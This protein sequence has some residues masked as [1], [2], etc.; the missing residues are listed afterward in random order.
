MTKD[1]ELVL[2]EEYKFEYWAKWLKISLLGNFG[3][4]R[5]GCKEH[6]SITLNADTD[7]RVKASSFGET[8]VWVSWKFKI[9][10]LSSEFFDYQDSWCKGEKQRFFNSQ[11]NFCLSLR[12]RSSNFDWNQ[13]KQPFWMFGLSRICCMDRNESFVNWI[14][15]R[16]RKFYVGERT[17]VVNGIYESDFRDNTILMND[18]FEFFDNRVY[19]GMIRTFGFLRE[20]SSTNVKLYIRILMEEINV[21]VLEK[22]VFTYG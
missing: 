10:K 4:S 16:K 2:G 5:F 21:V 1:F 12:Y 15:L 6:N 3:L 11:K 8:W 20:S 17:R 14:F 13:Y 18:L 22:K 7:G 9:K 19:H